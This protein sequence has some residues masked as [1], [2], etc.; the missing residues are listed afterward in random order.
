MTKISFVANKRYLS[1]WGNQISNISLKEN[2]KFSLKWWVHW[3]VLGGYRFA[4]KKTLPQKLRSVDRAGQLYRDSL[5]E[6]YNMF[7][8]WG[9]GWG[10]KFGREDKIFVGRHSLYR[11]Q[12]RG[13]IVFKDM[14]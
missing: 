2:L 10:G 5:L 14:A 8:V 1:V 4:T 6:K 9:L 11:W 7:D 13:G 3:I 12:Y